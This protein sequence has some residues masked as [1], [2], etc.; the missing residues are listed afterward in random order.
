[1]ADE[2][3]ATLQVS[4][5]LKTIG[6]KIADLTLKQARDLSEYLKE[7]HGIEPAAGGA[8]VGS[9]STLPASRHPA[10]AVTGHRCGH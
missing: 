8:D 10:A 1:M 3:T 7:A 9:G 2:A 5:D 6:D 4:D